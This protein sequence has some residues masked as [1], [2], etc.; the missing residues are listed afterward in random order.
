MPIIQLYAQNYFNLSFVL[1]N[2]I[3]SYSGNLTSEQWR[4][5]SRL[6]TI[7][8]VCF[9]HYSVVSPREPFCLYCNKRNSIWERRIRL[10][11]R[12]VY[13]FPIFF[14]ESTFYVFRDILCEKSYSMYWWANW[15]LLWT[16][17]VKLP[18][19]SFSFISL[20]GKVHWVGKFFFKNN[21]IVVNLGTKMWAV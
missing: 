5:T 19:S 11:L 21:T 7:F 12:A 20:S 8:F 16:S 3:I 10:G 1:K 9:L 4:G 18:V 15:V 2:F 13:F 17:Q 14:S 6:L